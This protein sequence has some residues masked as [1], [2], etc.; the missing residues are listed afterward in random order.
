MTTTRPLFVIQAQLAARPADAAYFVDF[1]VRLKAHI[2]HIA[3]TL[4]TGFC[5][6]DFHGQNAHIDAELVV[7]FFDFDCCG[8]GWRAYDL[9]VFFWYARYSKAH[10][11]RCPEFFR[12]YLAQRPLAEQ[13]I[14]AIPYFVAIRHLWW[15]ALIIHLAPSMGQGWIPFNWKKI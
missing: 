15:I 6:G 2:T 1:A 9:A 8:Q 11:Q 5:Y 7:T 14:A 12:S 4:D 10:Q 3:P 13:D